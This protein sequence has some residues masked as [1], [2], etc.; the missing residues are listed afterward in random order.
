[1]RVLVSVTVYV[2]TIYSQTHTHTHAHRRKHQYESC[3]HDMDRCMS[4]PWICSLWLPNEDAKFG[5][6]HLQPFI[7]GSQCRWYQYMQ[8]EMCQ[9]VVNPKS[10]RLRALYTPTLSGSPYQATLWQTEPLLS[11]DPIALPP[12]ARCCNK[13]FGFI[14]IMLF[15]PCHVL[16]IVKVFLN[17]WSETKTQSTRETVNSCILTWVKFKTLIIITLVNICNFFPLLFDLA[18]ITSGF[19]DCYSHL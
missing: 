5:I 18:V 16:H 10:W 8:S 7:L 11:C 14:S 3:C 15:E 2:C 12:A 13:T 6:Y 19:V 1:M 9:A 4:F 17:V